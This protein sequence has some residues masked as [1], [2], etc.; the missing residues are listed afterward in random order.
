M[1][2]LLP[3]LVPIAETDWKF[4]PMLPGKGSSGPDWF[5]VLGDQALHIHFRFAVMDSKEIPADFEGFCKVRLVFIFC[6]AAVDVHFG[7]DGTAEVVQ[8][9]MRP[10]FLYN[11]LVFFRMKC[12]KA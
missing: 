2:W 11:V 5:N 9:G 1:W 12:F 10:Y 6:P 7:Y 4:E 8:D 3:A